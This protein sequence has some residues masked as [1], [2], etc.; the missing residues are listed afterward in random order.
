MLS[1]VPSKRRWPRSQRFNLSSSGVAAEAKYREGISA[2]RLEGGRSAFDDARTSWAT[3][4]GVQPEDGVCLGEVRPGGVSLT[5][6]VEAMDGSGHT[7]TDTIE[8]LERLWDAG[9][10]CAAE[11]R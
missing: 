5:Q 6:V 9:L 10:V 2:A 8:A 7:R 11:A 4:L 1:D 3:T